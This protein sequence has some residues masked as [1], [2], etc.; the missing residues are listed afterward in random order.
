MAQDW[1]ASF[2]AAADQC[3]EPGTPAPYLRRE[4]NVDPGLVRATLHVTALGLVEAHLNG[5]VVG[6][7]VLAP[8]W[9]SHR[10]AKHFNIDLA[11]SEDML[12][13]SL[14]EALERSGQASPELQADLREALEPILEAT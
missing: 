6:D 3:G 9:T 12:D 14:R 1:Q 8:G 13:L 11:A 4:I 10:L 2:I 7:E 5:A